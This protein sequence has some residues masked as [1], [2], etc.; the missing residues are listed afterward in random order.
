MIYFCTNS[1]LKQVIQF[2]VLS[3]RG[4]KKGESERF[5]LY[6]SACG[7]I[8]ARARE[9]LSF[10]TAAAPIAKA[11]GLPRN[12]PVAVV[13]RTAFGHDGRPLEYRRSFG[14][15]ERFSYTVEIK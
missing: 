1:K 13:A 11:L 14:P 12:A 9:H 2:F 10:G 5:N 15:A 8:I 6:E 4:R 3:E 7:E